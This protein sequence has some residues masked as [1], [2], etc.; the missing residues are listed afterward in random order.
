MSVPAGPGR[1]DADAD[2]AGHGARIALG[3]MRGAF[4]MAREDVADGAAG[5][6]GRIERVDGGA[7]DTEGAVHAFLL[8]DPDCRVY[9]THLG[10]GGTPFS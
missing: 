3:H 6:H 10:H 1:A 5:L 7:G 2:I 9:G 4:D 8:Q